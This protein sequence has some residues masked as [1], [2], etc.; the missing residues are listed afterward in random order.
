M[1][2]LQKAD[3][4]LVDD[5][6]VHYRYQHTL[7]YLLTYFFVH[8]IKVEMRYIVGKKI[9]DSTIQKKDHSFFLF[10]SLIA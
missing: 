4:N 1:T 9:Q 7:W 3:L 5:Q 10:S 2:D 8:S 6:L